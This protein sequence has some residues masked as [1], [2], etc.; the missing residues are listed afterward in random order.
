MEPAI[1]SNFNGCL[2]KNRSVDHDTDEANSANLAAK[3]RTKNDS[4]LAYYD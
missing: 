3:G 2:Q 1:L 4:M